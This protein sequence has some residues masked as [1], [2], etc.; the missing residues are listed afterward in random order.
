LN[1]YINTSPSMMTFGAIN[2]P[3]FYNMEDI[4]I[5]ITIA[6]IYEQKK[7]R[8]IYPYTFLNKNT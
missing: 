5:M 7:K 4:G 8:H 3:H 2:N 1:S 6:D